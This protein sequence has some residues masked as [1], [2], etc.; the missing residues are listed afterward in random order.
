MRKHFE[1]EAEIK[2]YDPEFGRKSFISNG[3]RPHIAFGYSNP[4]TSLFSSDCIIILKNQ[5]RLYPGETAIVIIWVLKFEHLKLLLQENAML[6]IK[7]GSKYIGEG[8]I[9]RAFGE[10]STL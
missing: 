6:K 3:Y 1:I 9:T 4:A 5:D 8:T 2:L 10:K 7:E